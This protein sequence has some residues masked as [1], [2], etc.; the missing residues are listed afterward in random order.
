MQKW[1]R[2]SILLNHLRLIIQWSLR[3]TQKLDLKRNGANNSIHNDEYRNIKLENQIKE[4]ILTSKSTSAIAN[5]HRH[6]MPLLVC[7]SQDQNKPAREGDEITNEIESQWPQMIAFFETSQAWTDE[8]LSQEICNKL[9][10]SEAE[11]S[12]HL[13]VENNPPKYN[14]DATPNI[15]SKNSDKITLDIS[16]LSR[17]IPQYHITTKAVSLNS[18]RA[19]V[20]ERSF[21]SKLKSSSNK[22]LRRLVSQADTNRLD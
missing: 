21:L 9:D 4:T 18:A 14:G 13:L 2:R 12:R 3:L 11:N 5:K 20:Q 7:D 15:S 17:N 16:R 22:R 10:A 8:E 1:C 6:I 19:R